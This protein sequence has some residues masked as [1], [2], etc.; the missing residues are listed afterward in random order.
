MF[1]DYGRSLKQAKDPLPTRDDVMEF[2]VQINKKE[3]ENS[4]KLQGYP[5]DLQ[6]KVKWVFSFHIDKGRH[7]L[8]CCKPPRYSPHNSEFMRKLVERLD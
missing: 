3:L 4:L 5:S 2:D 1:R 7:S 8:I 6:Y